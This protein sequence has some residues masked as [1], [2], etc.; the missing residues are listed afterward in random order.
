MNIEINYEIN[1]NNYNKEIYQMSRYLRNK[2]KIEI[3]EKG[4]EPHIDIIS[5]LKRYNNPE[6]FNI[7]LFIL[8]YYTIKL[9][10][11]ST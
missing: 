8:L 10:L 3:R 9:A 5:S 11:L 2:K 4:I 1:K 7:V 6:L